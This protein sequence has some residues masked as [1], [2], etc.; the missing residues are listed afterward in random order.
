MIE[1]NKRGLQTKIGLK[2][3]YLQDIEDKS[4]GN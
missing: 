1:V 3:F 2:L 4:K